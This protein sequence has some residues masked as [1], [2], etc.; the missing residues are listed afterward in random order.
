VQG[1][2]V[3]VK[4]DGE[5]KDGITGTQQDDAIAMPFCGYNAA[6][7]AIHWTTLAH[8]REPTVSGQQLQV[9]ST[10]VNYEN[11]VRHL[12]GRISSLVQVPREQDFGIDFYC[13]PRVPSGQRTE[14]VTELCGI[15]VK[16]G[17][18]TLSFGGLNEKGQWRQFEF[19][20]LR[21]LA[22]PLFLARV[23]AENSVVD[24]YS[25]WRLWW[26]FI[27]QRSTPF[28]VDFTLGAPGTGPE[29]GPELAG[30]SCEAGQGHG[31]GLHWNID[32]GPPFLHLTNELLNDSGFR[33]SAV[34]ILRSR[35]HL[36]R[37]ML[38]RF[39]QFIPVLPGYFR[40]TTN[41]LSGADIRVW[42][43][44]SGIPGENLAA[45]CQTLVP[46][47]TNFGAHLQWQDDSAAY[48]LLLLLNWLREHEA[49]DDLAQGLLDGLLE[50]HDS[51]L[52]PA[53]HIRQRQQA[54]PTST[55]C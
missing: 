19:T 39:L 3:P 30:Q 12:L 21:S 4:Q 34:Q 15:Q 46:L 7:I 18:A 55:Q 16:G 8:F 28:R 35:I 13:Q 32:A 25:V 47:L 27:S 11:C 20:W 9:V 52:S 42:S 36:E 17:S 38:M 24:L 10:G 22:A 26:I 33:E 45:L 53:H 2:F 50:T 49:L 41:S 6:R 54:T 43:F 48:H 29:V 1:G 44:W 5:R 40:W 31:D 37:S 23:N 51:G 14:T